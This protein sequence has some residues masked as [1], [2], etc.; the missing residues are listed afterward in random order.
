[1]SWEKIKTVIRQNHRGGTD[2]FGAALIGAFIGAAFSGG[3][4]IITGALVGYLV[5]VGVFHLFLIEK[6]QQK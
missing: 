6:E 4:A 2:S 3:I 1:M 5:S